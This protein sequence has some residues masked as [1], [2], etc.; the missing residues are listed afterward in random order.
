MMIPI[1]MS[2][3]ASGPDPNTMGKYPINRTPPIFTE[4]VLCR[5]DMKTNSIPIKIVKKEII[6]NQTLYSPIISDINGT[7]FVSMLKRTL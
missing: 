4:F 1:N 5:E 3:F 2:V 6:N 7:I